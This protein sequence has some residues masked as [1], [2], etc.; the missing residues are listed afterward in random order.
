MMTQAQYSGKVTELMDAA[1]GGE[2]EYPASFDADVAAC[3]QQRLTPEQAAEKLLAE[4][5][6]GDDE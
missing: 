2:F 6:G 4:Y 3:F 1:T 5:A